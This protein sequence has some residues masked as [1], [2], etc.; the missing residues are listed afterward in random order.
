MI[1]ILLTTPEIKNGRRSGLP[2]FMEASDDDFLALP[3]MKQASHSN[4][5]TYHVRNG[6]VIIPAYCE[7][8]VIG[9]VV[10]SVMR[11]GY[12]VVVVDDGS[13]DNTVGQASA[14][15]AV[16][17]VHRVNLGQGAALETGMEWARR[18]GNC[19]WVVHFD[20]DG[21]HDP[22]AIQA[23]LASLEEFD[24]VMGSR[25]LPGASVPGIPAGR[26]RLLRL[27][28][29]I[30]RW[31]TGVPLT[32]AHCGLRALNEVAL[33]KIRLKEPGMAHA[34]EIVHRIKGYGLRFTELPVEISYTDYSLSKGQSAMNA[35]QILLSLFF[36]R[37][38]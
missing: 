4:P 22:R 35:I 32:D 10:E 33:D 36:R 38:L 7:A 28:S 12:R 30:Q 26:K 29:K 3:K 16:T 21:Q 25:F 37:I 34:T 9:E 13:Q 23:L 19:Q 5:Q 17:L 6:W 2:F 27:A 11:E 18:Q 14:A 8:M 1:P 20:A 24:I 15:G 31:M